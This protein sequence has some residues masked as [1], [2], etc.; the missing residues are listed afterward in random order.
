MRKLK[1]IVA[2]VTVALFLISVA[3]P[4]AFAATKEEAFGR[5]KAVNVAIGD[6]SGDPMYDKNFTRAEAAAIM[7][8]LS[9]MKEAIASAKGATKF[10][11]VPAS[12]W[13]S[14][15]VNLAVGAGIIKGYPDGSYKPDAN[16]TYAEMCAMLVQVLGYGP[17]L[18]GTWPTNVI[19]KAAQLGLLDG[20][21][22]SDYNGAAV[23]SN[24]FLASD[25][26]LDTKP[27]IEMKDGYEEDT[28]TLM[29]KKLN[30]TVKDEATV[31]ATPSYSTAL[32][33]NKVTITYTGTHT[34]AY[35]TLTTLET[36][37]PDDFY[38]LK[39]KAWVKDD[40]VFFLNVKNDS[41]DILSDTLEE[42]RNASGAVLTT[43]GLT[44]D[45]LVI[46]NTTFAQV[47]SVKLDTSDKVVTVV[48]GTT[49]YKK[50]FADLSGTNT[51]SNG[52]AVKVILGSDGKAAYVLSLGFK[53]AVVDSIDATN[54]KINLDSETLWSG[55]ASIELKDKK[56]KIFRNGVLAKLA[57]LKKGDVLDYID[58]GDVK[59][60]YANDK[61]ATGKLTAVY[62]DGVFKDK[63]WNKFKFKVGDKELKSAKYVFYSTNNGD[64]WSKKG[65][66]TTGSDNLTSAFNSLLNK[67]VTVKLDK[68][69]KAAYIIAG[70][71]ADSADIPVVVKRIKKVV[72][73]DTK[74]YIY[75]TKFDGTNTYYEV[76]KD[77]KIDGLKINESAL[78]QG[79]NINS[80][81]GDY[82]AEHGP[83]IL[84]TADEVK[85]GDVVKLNLNSDNT[86]NEIKNYDSDLQSSTTGFTVN[87]DNDTFAVTGGTTLLVDAD[88]KIL[89]AKTEITTGLDSDYAD[90]IRYELDVTPGL[91]VWD[92][93]ESVSWASVET[94]TS[95]VYDAKV[96]KDAGKAKYIAL[97]DKDTPATT[98]D[99]FGVVVA[100]GTNSNGD[101]FLTLGYDG[102]VEDRVGS[103]TDAAKKK[104]VKFKL[105]PDGKIDSGTKLNP[106][107]VYESTYINAKVDSISGSQLKL[108][109]A[110]STYTDISG[111]TAQYK[112]ISLTKTKVWDTEV[113]TTTPVVITDIN[114]IIGRY[115]QVYDVWDSDGNYTDSGDG[116]VDFVMMMKK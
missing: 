24:V 85:A 65:G 92:E 1:R 114:T 10:S 97:L 88:T 47:Y 2:L 28:K 27:L 3:A 13:A 64:T 34:P 6:T 46:D 50:N 74:R 110:T 83:R 66:G 18:Q 16:V 12:H 51:I 55:A 5:L 45:A 90:A 76:T 29:E 98:T 40:K 108:M 63:T 30:V 104:V 106:A 77:A 79:T 101:S 60:V 38:G 58:S 37:N 41:G 52:G 69:G 39:V 68:G 59:L 107:Y 9:G 89:K 62:D 112:L 94:V 22:V 36:V 33:K 57:D 102:K 70:A 81:D 84:T 87:K 80:G 100:L 11:D 82:S 20:V 116:I 44:P 86:V 73:T 48:P 15:V 103:I 105:K 93:F 32:D 17:K 67:D 42:L 4:S 14:G 43:V 95:G 111:A 25:N 21:S 91:I 71:A 78:K 23:R 8:N 53:N 96:V 31:T 113:D 7:V 56:V 26:A 49:T 115:V 54:E 75:V 35:E 109:P 19:G 99:Y 72:S 61:T